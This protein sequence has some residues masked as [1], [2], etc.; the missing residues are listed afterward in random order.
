M[1]SRQNAERL[2]FIFDPPAGG[3]I[4]LRS[5]DGRTFC[6]HSVTLGLA[7][8][9]FSDMFSIGKPCGEAIQLDDDSESISLMLAFIYPP[10]ISPNIKDFD[11]IEKCL[12][13]GRKY[14]VEK[15]P[16]ALDR[17]LSKLSGANTE[18]T[19]GQCRDPLRIFRFAAT[20]GLRN[21][22][23]LAAK[24]ITPGVIN[25]L[26]PAEIVKV[27]E[28]CPHMAHVIGLLGNDF[29][30]FLPT[31][32]KP[33]KLASNNLSLTDD[34]GSGLMMCDQCVSQSPELQSEGADEIYYF[35]SW[36]H[37]WSRAAYTKLCVTPLDECDHLFEL[38][39]F[40]WLVREEPG[41]CDECVDAAIE[42]SCDEREPSGQVYENWASNIKAILSRELAQLDV[43]YS[44]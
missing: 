17:D 43:L 33:L 5:R 25:L 28:E 20:Y 41:V 4:L 14:H 16:Q 30:D 36:V 11:I 2:D 12:V 32:W 31:A 22:Q 15:I 34:R 27:A 23:T 35:P 6:V 8:S 19:I 9:V 38:S 13:I 10:I 44:L 26:R 24:A 18:L 3:D 37:A 7:S 1:S 39:S 21:C 40:S 42:A 29:H